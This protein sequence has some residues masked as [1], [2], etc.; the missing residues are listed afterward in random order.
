K[1]VR[2]R[3]RVCFN[4]TNVLLRYS[5]AFSSRFIVHVPRRGQPGRWRSPGVG[6][7]VA[8]R[9]IEPPLPSSAILSL[10]FYEHFFELMNGQ[11]YS[12]RFGG[13][14]ATEPATLREEP[15][16]AA[17]I[18]PLTLW[19]DWL[20]RLPYANLN[21]HGCRPSSLTVGLAANDPVLASW[22]HATGVVKG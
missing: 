8:D 11:R 3:R 15:R 5:H 12:A 18:K 7:G 22:P 6:F 13:T 20:L 9:T 21:H 16:S 17:N 4:V 2:K 10:L 19:R 1:F 14:T